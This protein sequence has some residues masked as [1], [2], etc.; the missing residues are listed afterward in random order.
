MEEKHDTCGDFV[1][2][3]T[4]LVMCKHL[5][6]AV[7]TPAEGSGEQKASA[8]NIGSFFAPA[9]WEAG[10]VVSLIWSTHWTTSGLMPKRP[11]IATTKEFVLPGNKAIRILGPSLGLAAVV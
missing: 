6:A 2:K 8:A 1:L 11:M 10:L 4:T 9:I 5:K 3:A 7:G